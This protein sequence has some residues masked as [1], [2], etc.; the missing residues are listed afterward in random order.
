MQRIY[1]LLLNQYVENH[2]GQAEELAMIKGLS[3]R[4]GFWPHR[5]GHILDADVRRWY[6]I[7]FNKYLFHVICWNL[8]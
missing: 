4:D 7:W 8:L 2:G 6:M 3:E 5:T 1:F